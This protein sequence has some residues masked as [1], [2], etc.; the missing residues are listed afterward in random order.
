M[1]DLFIW[2]P[3][4]PGLWKL[5]AWHQNSPQ[6]NFSSEFEVKE[7]GKCLC[8]L[9]RN[10]ISQRYTHLQS[11]DINSDSSFSSCSPAQLRSLFESTES[12]LLCE[13]WQSNGRYCSQVQ[14]F[15]LYYGYMHVSNWIASTYRYSSI[16]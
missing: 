3:N 2:C 1:T 7:Y 6:K 12:L 15:F 8:E 16:S 14:S 13:W 9:L 11:T 5:V 4:S 10:N